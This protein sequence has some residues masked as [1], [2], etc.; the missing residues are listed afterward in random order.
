MKD[1]FKIK[2]KI[3]LQRRRKNNMKDSLKLR[4]DVVIERRTKDGKVIE[5]EELKNLIVNVGKER[6]AKMLNN[7][8]GTYFRAIAIGTGT[9]SPVVGNTALET[10]IT[11]ALASLSYE[12]NY[13]AIFEKTFVF[14]SGDNYDITE[15]G[16]LD[17]E[18]SGGTMLDRF[19]FSAK[20]VDADTDLY[21][22]VTITI[23]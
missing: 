3:E 22:K 5:K 10:E 15:A 16:I 2:D 21:I 13:K 1:N 8:D 18:T 19:T 4:G 12:A 17:N 14:G 20:S 9:T 11:R 23:A 7:V 6:V